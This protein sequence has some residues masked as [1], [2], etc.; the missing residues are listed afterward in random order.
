MWA[1]HRYSTRFAVMSQNKLHDFVA[2]FTVPL[3][4]IHQNAC[5]WLIFQ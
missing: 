5:D 2:G 3:L 1:Q 4:D